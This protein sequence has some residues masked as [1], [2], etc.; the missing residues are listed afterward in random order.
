[1]K[2]GERISF[3]IKERGLT[4]K[5]LAKR[6]NITEGA[7]SKYLN[8]ERTPRVDIITNIANVLNVTT[9][10][11]LMNTDN[12]QK[13]DYLNLKFVLARGKESLTEEEKK[14]LMKILLQ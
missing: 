8:D 2:L 1:M 9:D 5:E 4:Q 3:L 12:V 7:I 6:I 10:F 13:L 11:L 14:E